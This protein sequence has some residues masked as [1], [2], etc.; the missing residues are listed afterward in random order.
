MIF[1]LTINDISTI[2][3]VILWVMALVDRI[4]RWY[5]WPHKSQNKQ[6]KETQEMQRAQGEQIK[7]LTN[8]S[9]LMKKTLDKIKDNHLVH[10]QDDINKLK[11]SNVWIKT[12]LEWIKNKLN[13]QE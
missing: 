12:D 13:G 5:T 8:D 1:W 2:I 10:L 7:T 6:I 11:E 9:S 3:V 4:V